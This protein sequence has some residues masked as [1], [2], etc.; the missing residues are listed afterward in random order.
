MVTSNGS[1][2]DG[3]FILSSSQLFCDTEELKPWQG[4]GWAI[5]CCPVNV[6]AKQ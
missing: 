5:P 3:V 2:A 6:L 4:Q 1:A